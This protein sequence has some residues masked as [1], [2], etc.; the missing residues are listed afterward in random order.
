MIKRSIET[1]VQKYKDAN[2][3]DPRLDPNA[4]GWYFPGQRDLLTADPLPPTNEGPYLDSGEMVRLI[5]EG[6]AEA[7]REIASTALKD[8]VGM[9][10]S[11]SI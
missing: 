3:Y 4:T 1:L 8:T 10:D 6:I 9:S 2:A 5:E 11:Y 7:E